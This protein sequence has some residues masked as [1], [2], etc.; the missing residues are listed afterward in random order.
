M[1]TPGVLT[2]ADILVTDGRIA[3]IGANVQAPAGAEVIDAAGRPVTPGFFGGVGH[4]GVE[5]IGLEPTEGDYALALGQMRPEFDVTLAF[6]P[7]SAGDRRQPDR[8]GDLRRAG[9]HRGGGIG[10]SARW[11]R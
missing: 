2:G 3:A 1:G 4:L 7:A 8:R 6:N 9:S 5:E 11:H 10:G